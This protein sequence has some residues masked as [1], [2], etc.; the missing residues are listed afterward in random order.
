MPEE[1]NQIAIKQDIKVSTVKDHLTWGISQGLVPIQKFMPHANVDE[2][3]VCSEKLGTELL[4]VCQTRPWLSSLGLLL[5]FYF[6][7]IPLEIVVSKGVTTDECPC[8]PKRDFL[9][10]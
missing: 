6:D 10:K 4:M 9:S 5:H 7:S 3:I 1:L 8:R 2:I